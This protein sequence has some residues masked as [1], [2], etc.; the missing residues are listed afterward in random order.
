MSS[1]VE[2]QV[3]DKYLDNIYAESQSR[4]EKLRAANVKNRTLAAELEAYKVKEAQW[5][6][7]LEILRQENETLKQSPDSVREEL[8]AL[9]GQLRDSKHKAAFKRVAETNKVKSEAVE[10]LYK[11]TGYT[12]ESEDI[13]EAKIASVIQEAVKDRP[14]FLAAEES[15]QPPA[16]TFPAPGYSRGG[17]DSTPGVFTVKESELSTIGRGPD[18][19]RFAEAVRNNNVR[20]IAG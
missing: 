2:N 3:K 7:D 18:G 11:L 1:E 5:T 20:I 14:Y 8:E 6:K 4:K 19:K 9:K 13:D 16:P 17:V 10:D 12:A 15:N